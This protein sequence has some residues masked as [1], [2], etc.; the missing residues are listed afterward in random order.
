MT[1]GTATAGGLRRWPPHVRL[2]AIYSGVVLL[3]LT[4]AQRVLGGIPKQIVEVGL[5]SLLLGAFATHPAL[6]A[7][8]MR[9]SRLAAGVALGW[10]AVVMLADAAHPRT[11]LLF[12]LQKWHM[13]SA[14]MG[15]AAP[16]EQLRFIASYRGGRSSRVMPGTEISDVVASGLGG[17]LRELFDDLARHPRDP[18]L[19]AKASAAMRGVARL[20]DAAQGGAPI[21]AIEVERCT[22]F[23][24]APYDTRCVPVERY[25]GLAP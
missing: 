17:E 15:K 11:M 19:R 12:P 8:R 23:V 21:V 7:T 16:P 25:E 22:I 3:F 6:A 5:A 10:P 14:P 20:H 24:Q 2:L 1:L 4:G 13:F 18:A 9:V